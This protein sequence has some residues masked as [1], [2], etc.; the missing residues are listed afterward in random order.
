MLEFKVLN[1]DQEVVLKFEHSLLSLSK[2]ESKT[3][4]P[5]LTTDQKTPTQLLEYFQDMLL[6][7]E[8]DPDLVY[9]LDPKQMDRLTDYIN[10][11]RT[12]SSI[13]PQPTKYTAEQTTSELIYYWL[14]Q[15]KIPFHPVETWH[16]SRLLMLVQITGYKQ[17]PPKKRPVSETMADWIKKNNERRERFNTNG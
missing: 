10:E 12:A 15:L 2:W 1:G 7:P 3:R 16:L 4:K 5:F 14:V 13:P 6:P 17:Q 9:L 11:Q 8:D